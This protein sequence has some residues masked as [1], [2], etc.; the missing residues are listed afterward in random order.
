MQATE[1]AIVPATLAV[2]VGAAAI[3]GATDG[4]TV[5]DLD[6]LAGACERY[7][8]GVKP[9]YVSRP[10]EHYST[11]DGCTNGFSVG[12]GLS[13]GSGLGAGD[14]YRNGNGQGYSVTCVSGWGMAYKYGDV[15]GNGNSEP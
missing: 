8:V 1:T 7:F 2:T 14:G 15:R 5:T 9:A 13:R 3:Q 10:E 12:C 11:G 4:A 6:L